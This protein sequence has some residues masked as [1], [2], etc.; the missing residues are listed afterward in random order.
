[1]LTFL[2]TQCDLSSMTE[3]D[4]LRRARNLL[5]PTAWVSRRESGAAPYRIGRDGFF[6]DTV[7]CGDSWEEALDQLEVVVN[8]LNRAR[9]L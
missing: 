5:G 9:R 6:R 4:A 2:V 3:G 7:A 8:H 1:M